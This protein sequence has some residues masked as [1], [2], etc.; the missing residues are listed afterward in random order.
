MKS[1]VAAFLISS[2]L[3]LSGCTT[4]MKGSVNSIPDPTYIF[5]RDAPVIVTITPNSTNSLQSKYYISHVVSALRSHGFQKVFTENEKI[6]INKPTKMV[7]FV[8]VDNKIASYTYRG[9]D[10]GTV[11]TGSTTNCSSYGY[12]NI[13]TANCTTTPT[14]S[15]SVVGYSDKTGYTTGHFFSLSAFDVQSKQNV[16]SVM[17]SSF[18]SGCSDGKLYDFLSDQALS[19]MSFYQIVNQDFTVEMPEGYKCK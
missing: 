6:K 18:N 14:T 7:F 11:Q 1:I 10:Y 2:A 16:L 15:Y 5:D 3:A 12:G 9:A 13:G 19:R 8:D 4:F 17:A